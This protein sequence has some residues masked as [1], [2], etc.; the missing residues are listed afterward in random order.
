MC[1][2]LISLSTNQHPLQKTHCVDL[3]IVTGAYR[4]FNNLFLKLD[5]PRFRIYNSHMIANGYTNKQTSTL[6]MWI[7]NDVSIYDKTIE[8]FTCNAAN[9][10]LV[11]DFVSLIW[12][13]ANTD[14]NLLS[15][16]N[17]SEVTEVIND[18]I[19]ETI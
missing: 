2:L 17:W 5:Y 18:C 13:A 7:T 15:T 16:V 14:C 8:H 9:T 6:I 12:S 3:L 10:E 1:G 19:K 11:K 4:T